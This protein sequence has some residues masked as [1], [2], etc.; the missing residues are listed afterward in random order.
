MQ[1]RDGTTRHHHDAIPIDGEAREGTGARGGGTGRT[2]GE[3]AR[4]QEE[5]QQEKR[6]GWRGISGTAT[7]PTP[8]HVEPRDHTRRVTT[9]INPATA[10]LQPRP[11][12]RV[13]TISTTQSARAGVP[14]LFIPDHQ[15]QSFILLHS[16]TP[17]WPLVGSAPPAPVPNPLRL[18]PLSPKVP[19]HPRP[20]PSSLVFFIRSSKTTRAPSSSFLV[21][22]STGRLLVRPR[23]CPCFPHCPCAAA[24]VRPAGC[25]RVF[26]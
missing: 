11:P 20:C 5:Q 14:I 2:R 7:R 13:P 1:R 21:L 8:R 19:P 12:A 15:R 3:A 6:R 23:S 26:G 22:P 10:S 16:S 24:P 17:P 18:P 9:L 4:D 25:A